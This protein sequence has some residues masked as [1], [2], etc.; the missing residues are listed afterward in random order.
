MSQ[1]VESQEPAP[2][3]FSHCPCA[4][5]TWRAESGFKVRSRQGK[6]QTKLC[7]QKLP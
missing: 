4:L 1:S 3:K 5:D 6:G 7:P 2:R